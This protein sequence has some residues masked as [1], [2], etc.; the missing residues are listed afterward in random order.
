MLLSRLLD[1]VRDMRKNKVRAVTSRC[2]LMMSAHLEPRFLLGRSKQAAVEYLRRF[3]SRNGLSCF[4]CTSATGKK[5]PAFIVFSGATGGPVHCELQA[6]PLHK[7][8]EVVLTVQKNAYCDERIMIECL[9]VYKMGSVRAKLEEAMTGVDFV[10][11]GA[12]GL[13]QPM[14][15]SVMRVL[16]TGVESYTFNTTLQTTLA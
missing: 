6:H 8:D 12:T 7:A 13:A 15:V 14:D 16:N 4:L 5:L 3:R 9:K 1:W 2:L 10:P 11:A